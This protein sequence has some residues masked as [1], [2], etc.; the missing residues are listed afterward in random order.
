MSFATASCQRPSGM[1]VHLSALGH[2]I[3]PCTIDPL[4]DG[5]TIGSDDGK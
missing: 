5:Q 2:H 4:E 1:E 3:R